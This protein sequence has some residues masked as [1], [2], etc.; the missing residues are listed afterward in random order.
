LAQSSFAQT[1]EPVSQTELQM[2]SPQVEA[3]ADAEVLFWEVRIEDS[4][5]QR[6]FW[7]STLNHH[8][9]IK[10]FTDRG[11]DKNSKVDIPFGNIL[12]RDSKVTIADIAARTI[13]QDGSIVELKPEDVFERDIIKGS[14][15][16][17]KAKSFAVPGIETGAIIEYRWKEVR[18]D[19]FNYS[20]IELAR[21]IPVQY[22]KYFIKP[23]NVP[24]GM[25]LHSFNTSGGFTQ[26]GASGFYSTTM[27]NVPALK[28]EPRMPSEY[29]VKPWVLVF[30]DSDKEKQTPESYWKERGKLVYDFYKTL[31]KPSGEIKAAAMQA[32]GDA[33]DPQEKVRRIFEYCRKN[34]KNVYDDAYGMTADQLRDFKENKS[35][36]EALK[37]KQGNWHDIDMVFASM[38]GAVGI[39]ARV[40]NVSIRNDARFDKQFTNAYFIRTVIIAAKIG[41]EWQFFD[42]ANRNLPFGMN[43]WTIEGQEAL[44]S[45][46]SEPFWEKTSAS[47]A[48]QSNE[49]RAAKLR[50]GEDGSLEGDVRIEYAGHL[51]DFYREYNDDEA[52]ADREKYLIEMIKRRVGNAAEVT[53]ISIENLEDTEKPFVYAFKLRVPAYAERTG[54]RIFLRPNIFERNTNSLFTAGKRKYD[55]FFEYAWSENDSISIE[56]PK[57]FS[58]EAVDSPKAVKDEKTGTSLETAIS[59][60]DDKRRLNYERRFAYGKPGSLLVYSIYYSGVKSLFEAIHLADSHSLVLRETSP[61]TD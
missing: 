25:R 43:V 33:T 47:S 11:R 14:G 7:K 44:I 45:D 46:A 60:S 58:P 4:Y 19:T 49:K 16:K 61:A 26:E 38:L 59:L 32:I 37:R 39:D 28:D 27:R 34:I 42:L 31:L 52:P 1:W 29:E 54:K 48:A 17:I 20:R 13:K 18:T 40:A 56:F 22:V 12:D 51:A 41:D 8:M 5:H 36:T 50:L 6:A 2:K 10:V 53:N 35:P 9:R 24:V 23:A 57:G 21:E 15:V 3:D 55:I 30:Y